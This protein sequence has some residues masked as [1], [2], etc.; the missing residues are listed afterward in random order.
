[1]GSLPGEKHG[2]AAYLTYQTSEQAETCVGKI[3]NLKFD[4]KHTLDCFFLQRVGDVM[5]LPKEYQQKEIP[6]IKTL[7]SYNNDRDYRDQIMYREQTTV[8]IGWFENMKKLVVPAI[9]SMN[10]EKVKKVQFSVNG[11]YLAA[12]F[13]D[14]VRLYA[15][16]NMRE[17]NFYPHSGVRDIQFSP[18]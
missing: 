13:D 7:Q 6:K 12:L 10:L 2:S 18:N 3:D 4:A 5:N 8:N 11:T 17:E 14:G 16:E 15:G 9:P 1:M